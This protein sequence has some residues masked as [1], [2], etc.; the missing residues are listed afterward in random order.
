MTDVNLPVRIILSLH[1]IIGTLLEERKLVQ[2]LGEP[3]IRYQQQVPMLI[4]WRGRILLK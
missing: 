1:L 2:E 4:P 3:Y